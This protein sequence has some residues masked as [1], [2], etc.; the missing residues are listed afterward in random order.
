MNRQ[1]PARR[2]RALRG[3]V[4]GIEGQARDLAKSARARVAG[5]E[6]D[7]ASRARSAGTHLRDYV[8]EHPW[9]ILGG[10]V[11]LMLVSGALS[12]GRA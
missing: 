10:F 5:L 7:A 9:L 2:R 4:D 6:H 3:L 12:R 1:A 8:R 11:V